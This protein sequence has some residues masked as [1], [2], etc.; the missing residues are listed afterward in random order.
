MNKYSPYILYLVIALL[1]VVLAANDFGPLNNLQRSLDDLLCRFTAP[2]GIRPNV[3]LIDIDGPAQDEYGQLPWDHDLIADLTAAA[4]SGE[5]KAI[6]LN[7]ELYEDAAQESTGH[8]TVLAEQ[9]AWISQ[10]VL[11]YDVAETA[12]RSGKT[13]NPEFLFNNS[14]VVDNPLGLMDEC[15]SL[16]VRKV[17]LPA[18]KLLTHKP[19]LGFAYNRPDEDRLLR[20]Q[21]LVM[22]Y[23]G[24]YYPSTS[25]LTAATYW[26]VSPDEIKITEGREI[27][28]GASHT[29]PINDQGEFF[30]RF[31]HG[32]PFAKF[33]ASQVLSEDFSLSMLR[34]K[35]VVIGMLNSEETEY[36]STVAQ[37]NMADM[38]IE[39]TVIENILNGNIVATRGDLA[40][41][42][43]IAIFILGAICAFVLPRVNMM[44]RMIILGGGLILLANANYLLFSS[45]GIIAPTIYVGLEL[46][47]FMIASPILDSTL[48]RGTDEEVKRHRIKAK[49][50]GTDAGAM[51]DEVPVREAKATA[52]DPK[53]I[54]TTAFVAE[55]KRSDLSKIDH[56][57]ISL[58]EP[59]TDETL[60]SDVVDRPVAEPERSEPDQ[61]VHLTDSDAMLVDKGVQESTQLAGDS[62]SFATDSTGASINTTG[63]KSLGRYQIQGILGK[64]AMG[65]VY[66]G[67]DPAINRPVA[68][69]TIRLDFVSDPEEM[70]ELKERLHREAQAAGKLSHPNI[71]TI[72][73]V[74]SEGSLQYIAMEYLEG[75]TLEEMI[76]KKTRF[77]YRIIAQMISQ[78]C[79]A[80]E[81]AH[82]KGIVHRD[83]KP[84]NIMVL[85][86]YRVKVMDY[87][88]AR[89]DSNSMTKTGIAMGTPNYIS[90]EQL[91][92]LEIDRRADI[93]SLGVI[94][95]EMLLGR[96]PFKGENLTSLMYA[97]LNNEP[98]KPSSVRPQ[99]PLLFDHIIGKAL[100][101]DP[102]DR[103]QK[104]SEIT[105]DLQD[106]VESFAH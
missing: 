88:I 85:G 51:S 40:R 31:S 66:R 22:N 75:Q 20:H 83:I 90:P 56:Q 3:V 86:D 25:L 47:L 93:F 5:P 11:P 92:G 59:V 78:I 99:I 41:Y 14:I 54:E 77:N 32:M 34:N 42:S 4:A 12:F 81:Y 58:D 62:Q 60:A 97:V 33:S 19:L 52:S 7:L 17:F 103:Y 44:Y 37:E 21:P 35:A 80:L 9:L 57:T 63:L 69:K 8:T 65:T 68:L 16:L 82:E 84:A 89:V 36:F 67:V 38:L 76:K 46:V 101:K 43:L 53:N 10:A 70:A 15:S 27:R 104:A 2:E 13:R 102:A 98:E 105:A 64:G 55:A 29:V 49:M 87:G 18:E 26:G 61:T 6:L 39:A 74:G 45:Y 30:V 100:M 50:A 96:R 71:V 1:V 95:Y 28:I 23:D 91:K 24:Y 79:Q 72:Y 94:I 73:D 106:F 48:L